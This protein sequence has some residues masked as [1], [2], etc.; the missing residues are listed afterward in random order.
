VIA[1]QTV[2]LPAG[3]Y[4]FVSRYR[5]AGIFPETGLGWRLSGLHSGL[6]L[7]KSRNLSSEKF[8]E[9]ETR[10]SVEGRDALVR[11]E[12]EYRR[13]IGTPRISGVLVV[14]STTIRGVSTD[15]LSKLR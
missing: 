9:Q 11:L 4:T 2:L 10:F 3:Q 13:A 1:E 15:D 7:S 8:T 6:A 5:T 12:L 14:S